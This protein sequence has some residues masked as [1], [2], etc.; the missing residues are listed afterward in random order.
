[1]RDLMSEEAVCVLCF[2]KGTGF[3]AHTSVSCSPKDAPRHARYLRSCGYKVRIVT[4]DELDFYYE[5][6]KKNRAKQIRLMEEA[7]VKQK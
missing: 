3:L 2:D 1:M 7:F 5:Q 4:Y 6:D